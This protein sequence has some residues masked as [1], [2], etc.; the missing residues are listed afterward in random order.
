MTKVPDALFVVD[1][2]NEHTSVYE[3]N[4]KKIP[5]VALLGTDCDITKVQ[6]PI[7]GNDSSRS[8]IDYMVGKVVEAYQKGKLSE[9]K[10]EISN[11]K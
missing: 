2:R 7:V 4:R 9:P 8:S 1:P 11:S 5:V 3:A 6:Y 10:P